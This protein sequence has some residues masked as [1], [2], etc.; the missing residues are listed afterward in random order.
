VAAACVGRPERLLA[1]QMV[2]TQQHG[3]QKNETNRRYSMSSKCSEAGVGRMLADCHRHLQIDTVR[4][5]GHTQGFVPDGHYEASLKLGAGAAVGATS[6]SA[7]H[8][9]NSWA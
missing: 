3:A 4:A 6:S 1:A 8:E 7:R 2:S 5:T 9:C